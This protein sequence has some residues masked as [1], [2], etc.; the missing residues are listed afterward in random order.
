MGY[1]WHDLVERHQ[2]L[3]CPRG[4]WGEGLEGMPWR[5]VGAKIGGRLNSPATNVGR[6]L[7]ILLYSRWNYIQYPLTNHN[8]KEYEKKNITEPL[9]ST[10]ET[11]TT[12]WIDYTWIKSKKKRERS[13]GRALELMLPSAVSHRL[14]TTEVQ[15]RAG[16]KKL[17]L[18][19]SCLL[20]LWNNEEG[21]SLR[22]SW[23]A[24]QDYFLSVTFALSHF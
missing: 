24:R 9:C 13:L 7:W 20:A 19:F 23:K 17:L 2:S 21:W 15:K 5:N 4:K 10:E 14:S 11:N 3:Q 16:S 12:L 8:G 1:H 22:I 6:H 18:F